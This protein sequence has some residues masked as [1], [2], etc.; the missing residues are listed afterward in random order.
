VSSGAPSH[1]LPEIQR[2]LSKYID[3]FATKV[4]FPPT[5]PYSHSIP[6]I[7]G[8]TPVCIRP[9]RYASGLKDEIER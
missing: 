3:V 2:L 9:Y 6:L 7:D 1:E 8:A 5:R 4:V